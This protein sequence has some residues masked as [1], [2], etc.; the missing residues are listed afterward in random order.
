M[1][2]K[3]LPAEW[4]PQSGVQL[5]W[6]H[7]ETDWKEMLDEVLP[8]FA[9]IASEIAK[10]EQLIIVC[11]DRNVVHQHLK[12]FEPNN[13]VLYEIPSNDTWARD[14]AP[15]SIVENGKP[16]ILDFTFNGWGLQYAANFD[17]QINRHLYQKRAF[18]DEVAYRNKMDF[19]LE[20]GS[21][22]TDGHGTLLTT[23]RCLLSPNRNDAKTIH[24]I[25]LYLKDAFGIQRFLWL[26]HGYLAGD[27]TGSHIDTLARFCDKDTIAYVHCDDLNDEHFTE[28]TLM[29]QEIKQFTREDGTPYRLIPLPMADA[30]YHNDERLPATY[31]N[32]LIINHAVLMPTYQSPKDQIAMDQLK[33]AFPDRQIIGINCLPLIKQHGSLHCVTM[34]YPAQF[35]RH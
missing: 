24:D 10:Q 27:D 11:K 8:C 1:N 26:H 33:K 16:V 15:I 25:E 13:M 14:H 19:V 18:A 21:I 4:E 20:G 12:I 31:A 3:R 6:P 23:S 9:A 30:V 5:T 7:E 35:L 32:F 28:L 2:T 22:E 17:N 34:Q 29:E